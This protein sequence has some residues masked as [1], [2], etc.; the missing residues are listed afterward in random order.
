MNGADFLPAFEPMD[1][2]EDV[3]EIMETET[4]I[5]KLDPIEIIDYEQ[6]KGYG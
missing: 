4:N 5:D 2:D 1:D 6:F 3:E